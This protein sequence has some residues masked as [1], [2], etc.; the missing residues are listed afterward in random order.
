[1]RRIPEILF[2]LFI[3][4]VVGWVVSQSAGWMLR[5]IGWHDVADLL[6]R[7]WGPR[8]GLFPVVIALPVLAMAIV[9]LVVDV[10]AAIQVRAVEGPSSAPEAEVPPEVVRQRSIVILSTIVGWVLAIW[11]LGFIVS[12]PLATFLYLKVGARESWRI[13]LSLAAAAGVTFYVFF[14]YLLRVPAPPGVLLAPFFE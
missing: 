12:T 7:G 9:Q 4:V 3:V 5:A 11:A 13:S 2:S 14:V 6:P 8:S 1:M 10:R